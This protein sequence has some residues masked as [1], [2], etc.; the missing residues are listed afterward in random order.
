[1]AEHAS[2]TAEPPRDTAAAALFHARLRPHCSLTQNG[3]RVLMVAV[4]LAFSGIGSAFYALGA[5]PVAG[6]C[7]LEVL[8]IWWCFKLNF[9]HLERYETILMT[10]DALE[11]RRVDPKG[12]V[13]RIVL[14]PYWLSVRLEE[15][16]SGANRLLLRSHGR[17]V[18][19][20]GFLSPE[21][22]VDLKQALDAA[23]RQQRS[24]AL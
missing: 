12:R 19:I 20:G 10:A 4:V 21:E 1:M 14:Q 16:P 11:I 24:P 17:D 13:E 7:G 18:A 15:E 2:G 9:R 23:L 6:F 8:L 5:W 3:F 22:R